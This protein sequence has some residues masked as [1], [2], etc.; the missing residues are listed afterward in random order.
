MS[1]TTQIAGLVLAVLL[2]SLVVPGHAADATAK[3]ISL[4]PTVHIFRG[5]KC[6]EPTDEMRRN[7][8]KKILHQRDR[9]MHE[10]IRT[11]K[12]SLRQC[13]NCHADPKTESV[14]GKEGFCQGCHS[15]AAVNMDCFS[16]HTDK[17][18]KDAKVPPLR[19]SDTNPGFL[20][21]IASTTEL[22]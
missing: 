3:K 13:I 19:T 18:E 7:H 2:A 4:E 12:Y 1:H 15:Y 11:T 5:E 8:M 14:L 20:N 9:T 16:C 17:A 10:G 21:R 22:K 6:V